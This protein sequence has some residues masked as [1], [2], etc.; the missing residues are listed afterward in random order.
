MPWV[1]KLGDDVDLLNVLKILSAPGTGWPYPELLL[2][3]HPAIRH[4]DFQVAGLSA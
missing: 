2:N 4:A 3:G 1:L